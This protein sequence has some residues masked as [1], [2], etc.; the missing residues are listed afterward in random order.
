M[1]GSRRGTTHPQL[2]PPLARTGCCCERK[3]AQKEIV[4][5]HTGALPAH[6]SHH[7]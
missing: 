5:W 2:A 7:R 3:T 6:Q 1:R 4:R